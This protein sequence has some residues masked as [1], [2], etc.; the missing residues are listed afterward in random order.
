M[1]HLSKYP[2]FGRNG[3]YRVDV[4]EGKSKLMTVVIYKY[5]GKSKFLKKD[6]YEH[7]YGNHLTREFFR[8][9]EWN[10]DYVTMAKH[11]VKEYEDTLEEN[12]PHYPM[13]IRGIEAFENWDGKT[14]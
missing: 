13:K 4:V 9:K 14:V 11:Q 12:Q 7:L 1:V 2:V 5:L 10:Y 6:Q 3:I 8:P